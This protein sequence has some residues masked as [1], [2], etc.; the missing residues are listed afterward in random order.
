V[1]VRLASSA[2]SMTRLQAARELSFRNP[3][4]R[5][6]VLFMDENEQYFFEA[7]DAGAGYVLKSV[8]DQDLLNACHAAMRGELFIDPGV[9]CALIGS[10]WIG[11]AG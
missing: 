8:A 1:W 6:P 11:Y 5:I 3:H 2:Q 4:P 10:H 7:L 9:M